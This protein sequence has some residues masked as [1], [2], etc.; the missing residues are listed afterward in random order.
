MHDFFKYIFIIK[1]LT[2]LNYVS[3]NDISFII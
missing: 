1:T 2:T 3:R